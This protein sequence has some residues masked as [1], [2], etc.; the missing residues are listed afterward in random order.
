M[1]GRAIKKQVKRKSGK[2][3]ICYFGGCK[4]LIESIC[5]IMCDKNPWHLLRHVAHTLRIKTAGMT[6]DSG[7]MEEFRCLV[8]DD[9]SLIVFQVVSHFFHWEWSVPTVPER[10]GNISNVDFN[11]CKSHPNEYIRVLN[12]YCSFK[13]NIQFLISSSSSVSLRMWP[14]GICWFVTGFVWLWHRKLA[15]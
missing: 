9:F 14:W 11:A 10:P 7:N 13:L 4:T 3:S 2:A 1:G 15:C 5:R 6:G 12:S 8:W